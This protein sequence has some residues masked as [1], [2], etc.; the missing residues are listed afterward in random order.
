MI[1]KKTAIKRKVIL[2]LKNKESI[3]ISKIVKI[4]KNKKINCKNKILKTCDFCKIFEVNFS[5]SKK[6]K[7]KIIEKKI[8]R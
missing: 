4:V 6:T 5:Y 7:L 8:E 2:L 1:L 3:S